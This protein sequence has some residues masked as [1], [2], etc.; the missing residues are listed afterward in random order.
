M[1]NEERRRR[2]VLVVVV[3][4]NI[5]RR[6]GEIAQTTS[7]GEI[8]GCFA[9]GII[10]IYSTALFN[11]DRFLSVSLPALCVIRRPRQFFVAFGMHFLCT[12][13]LQSERREGE[14]ER[15]VGRVK[16]LCIGTLV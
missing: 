16:Y 13:I 15:R 1:S 3:L 12:L 2:I 11:K 7:D 6:S 4:G 10:I 5:D 8:I 9:F 14:N